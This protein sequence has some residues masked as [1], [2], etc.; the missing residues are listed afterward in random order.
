MIQSHCLSNV[1]APFTIDH[2]CLLACAA[3]CCWDLRGRAACW[4]DWAVVA[5]R[6]VDRF[7]IVWVFNAECSWL[8]VIIAVGCWL[9]YWSPISESINLKFSNQKS[10]ENVAL[11]ITETTMITS[12]ITSLA[13]KPFRIGATAI[14][15]ALTHAHRT[16]SVASLA[17]P[18]AIISAIR[19]GAAAAASSF[20]F[21]WSIVRLDSIGAY[22]V[23]AAIV[24][25]LMISNMLHKHNNDSYLWIIVH[26]DDGCY[27]G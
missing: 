22:P 14:V 27:V 26:T 5:A 24:S 7:S 13:A 4:V 3:A 15:K 18:S 12:P 16:P 25:S 8:V 2:D 1:P 11:R 17:S 6:A 19:G 20:D 23:V 10:Q 9:S 21:D